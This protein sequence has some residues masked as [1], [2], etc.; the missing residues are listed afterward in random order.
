[1]SSRTLKHSQSQQN[2]Q[3]ISET[4]AEA[5]ARV[6]KEL[7]GLLMA[8]AGEPSGS[9]HT[10]LSAWRLRVGG[11]L[12][13]ATAI[14]ANALQGG[15]TVV[16]QTMQVG[17]ATTD[18]SGTVPSGPGQQGVVQGATVDFTGEIFST[19]DD[20]GF[21]SG[22]FTLPPNKLFLLSADFILGYSDTGAFTDIY[23]VHTATGLPLRNGVGVAENSPYDQTQYSGDSHAQV[24]Y[25]TGPVAEEVELR[26]LNITA[27]TIDILY[28][29][30][31]LIHEI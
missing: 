9:L 28:G 18:T 14:A 31:A 15:S 24:L 12:A 11:L 16:K 6:N 17:Y 5:L 25:Q 23:W 27:G 10:H 13:E 29:S 3:T 4:P 30:N 8:A 1:M 26:V 2:M 19:G 20:I 22:V 7:H 21:I